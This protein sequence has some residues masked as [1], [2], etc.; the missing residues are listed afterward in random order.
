MWLIALH[1]LQAKHVHSGKSVH[2]KKFIEFPCTLL[3]AFVASRLPT[4][5]NSV[6]GLPHRKN[7]EYIPRARLQLGTMW[8]KK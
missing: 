3:V 2:L 1:E 8:D 7:E 4:Y 5:R 6:C